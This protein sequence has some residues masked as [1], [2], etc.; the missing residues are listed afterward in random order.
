MILR[1]EKIFFSLHQYLKQIIFDN[2]RPAKFFSKKSLIFLYFSKKE[3]R[4]TFFLSVSLPPIAP[5]ALSLL[6]ARKGGSGGQN[7]LPYPCFWGQNSFINR[8][9]MF[10]KKKI[11]KTPFRAAVYH[12]RR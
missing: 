1:K 11:I 6:Y 3:M 9:V 8:G 2:V 5:Q 10:K 12:A 7:C 4:S